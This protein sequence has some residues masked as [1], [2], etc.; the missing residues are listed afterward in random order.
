MEIAFVNGKGG[1]GKST[2]C[3]LTALAM[4]EAGKTVAIDDRD[5]QKSVSGW[6]NQ[7][8]DD[9]ALVSE[10]QAWEGEIRLVDTRPAIDDPSVHRAIRTADIV[11]MPCSPSPGD[12]T[13]AKATVE[14]VREFKSPESKAAMVLN[15]VKPGTVL[16]QEAPEILRSLGVPVLKTELPDRQS[17]QRAVLLGWPA[18]DPK[19]Q[20]TILTL[21]LEVIAQ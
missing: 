9:I 5:P 19:T 17:I 4:R 20:S 8:R 18:L 3:L 16:A 21:A 1:V 7:E 12:M 13:T 11:V 10:E 14:V 15:M 6:V 2:L